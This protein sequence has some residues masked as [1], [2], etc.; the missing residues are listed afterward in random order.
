MDGKGQQWMIMDV[1]E[2]EGLV[3]DGWEGIP[4]DGNPQKTSQSSVRR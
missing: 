1:K 4:K 3:R 2:W